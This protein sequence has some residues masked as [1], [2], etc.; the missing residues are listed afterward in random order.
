MHIGVVTL[1]VLDQP[2]HQGGF[3]HCELAELLAPQA[4]RCRRIGR[5]EEAAC[6]RF[7]AVRALSEVHGVEVLLEDLSLRVLVVQA[8]GEDE[9]LHLPLQI[10]LVAKNPVLDQ[11]LCDRR[12]AL[13][14][15]AAREVLDERTRHAADVDARVRPERLVL[16]RDHRVDQDLRHLGELGRLTVLHAELADRR[17][18]RVEHR[19]RLRQLAEA[20]D[21]RRIV[22]RNGDLACAGNQRGETHTKNEAPHQDDGREPHKNATR[23]CHGSGVS[24]PVR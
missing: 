7:H 17:A 4:E 18:G 23:F 22:I 12:A 10:T 6:G 9:L 24:P 1:G 13:A 16:G 2:R 8:V 3:A 19:G 21:R 5:E 15:L 14:D 11:L 20:S